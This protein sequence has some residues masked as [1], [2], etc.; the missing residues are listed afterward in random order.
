M[1]L[2]TELSPEGTT[3]VLDFEGCPMNAYQD[4]G[5]VWTIGPGFTMLSKVFADYWL[6]SRGHKLRRGDTITR[7]EVNKLFPK[8]FNEEYGAAVVRDIAPTQQHIYDG[9]GSVAYNA[10]KGSLKWKWALAIK[11]GDIA[12]AARLLLTTAI[13]AGG[14][15]VNG[16]KRRRK[17]ESHLLATGE[18]PAQRAT[19]PTSFGSSESMTIDEIKEYQTQL[20]KLGYYTGVIDGSKGKLTKGAIENFQRKNGLKVDGLV[21][22]ATRAA[23]QRALAAKTQNQATT[24]GAVVTTGGTG[25]VQVDAS[26]LSIDTVLPILLYGSLAAAVIFLG[27]TLWAHRGVILGKRTPA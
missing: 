20:A 22:P 12:T 9:S 27:F 25:A 16:L 7:A 13:T 15:V 23:L 17:A 10:G 24:G 11:T 3:M 26:G 1:A 2:I 14:R 19:S 21:G 6:E 4:I 5:G 8:V 18:Y